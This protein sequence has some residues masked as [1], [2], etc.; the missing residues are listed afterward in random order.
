MGNSDVAR[1]AK[2]TPGPVAGEALKDAARWPGYG[3]IAIGL[4]AMALS[5]AGF[6]VGR[7][8]LATIGAVVA[9]VALV[10]GVTWQFVEHRRLRTRHG[11][12]TPERPEDAAPLS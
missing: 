10:A 4:V 2:A 12:G 11:S 7:D 6:A 3:L 8:P 1:D 5:L 9:A